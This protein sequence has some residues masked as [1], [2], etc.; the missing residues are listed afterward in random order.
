MHNEGIRTGGEQI[1]CFK[2]NQAIGRQGIGMW[3]Y[4]NTYL[5][6]I[7]AKHENLEFNRKVAGQKE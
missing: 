6:C 5:F 3:T 1:R 7:L 4:V 2:E